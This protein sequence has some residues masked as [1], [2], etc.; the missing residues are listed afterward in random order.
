VATTAIQ[1]RALHRAA[2]LFNG[3]A[4]LARELDVPEAVVRGWLAGQPVPAS[5]F[6]RTVTMIL[7]DD[8]AAL[9][10]AGIPHRRTS[11]I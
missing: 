8:V 6:L 10:S 4:G 3:A 9:Q 1:N 2:E 7:E 11:V 5:V